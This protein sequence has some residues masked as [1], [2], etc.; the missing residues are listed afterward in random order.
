MRFLSYMQ[1]REPAG[2]GAFM[3]S[4]FGRFRFSKA[5]ALFATLKRSFHY[6]LLRFGRAGRFFAKK[7]RMGFTRLATGF[8]LVL[9]LFFCMNLPLHAKTLYVH[10]EGFGDGTSWEDASFDLAGILLEAE[11]GDEVWVAEGVYFPTE[12]DDRHASFIV[13]EGVKVYG[14]FTGTEQSL[15]QRRWQYHH[16]ILSGAIG[17]P[18][19][20]DNSYT[21]VYINGYS[22]ETVLDGFI[23]YGAAANGDEQATL[24]EQFGGGL[25]IEAIPGKVVQPRIVNCSFISNTGRKGAAVYAAAANT[26]LQPLFANCVFKQNTADLDGGALYFDG[27]RG[28]IFP[29]FNR[30]VF[31]ENLADYGGA[32]C[33]FAG[34]GKC[35]VELR[36]CSFIENTA[37]L[38][39]GGIY[40][41]V[42]T[43]GSSNRATMKLQNCTFAE[44]YPSDINRRSADHEDQSAAGAVATDKK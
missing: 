5:V 2:T 36:N 44:N 12:F 35:T 9:C 22:A 28:E 20:I 4:C 8:V 15:D 40:T 42:Q 21:V 3:A 43:A 25:F 14:G 6:E 13:K 18:D 16:T 27:H 24:R 10:P 17:G 19:L 38:W 41:P 33:A 39:G 11:A 23:I 34:S 32:I 31:E 1:D 37:F 29:V 7:R 26:R 30:C